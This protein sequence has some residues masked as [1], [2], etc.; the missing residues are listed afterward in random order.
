[1]PGKTSNEQIIGLLKEKPGFVSGETMAAVLGISRAA[2]WKRISLLRKSG[3]NIEASYAR[4]Y[5][6]LT[7]PDLSV[8]EIRSAFPVRQAGLGRE[9]ILLDR[10][11]STNTYAMELAARGA[12]EGTVILANEQ[13][14]GRGRRGRIWISPRGKSLYMSVVLRPGISPRDATILTFLSAVAV[15][16]AVSTLTSLPVTIKWPN[17]LM[18]SGRKLGGILTEMKADMDRIFHAVVGIGVNI[19]LEREALPEEIRSIATSVLAETG[20]SFRRAPFAVGILREMEKQYRTL[21]EK[22]RHPLLQE[23]LSLN[24]T[25]G[26][27]VEVTAGEG[28]IAGFAEGIDDEGMLL[29]RLP[30]GALRR[31]GSGDVTYGS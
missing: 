26:R 27:H 21:Q 6:L 17:D 16:T 7:S 20:K 23:W 31:I 28:K 9:V 5:R 18:V 13:T 15:A 29:L 1:M 10:I 24:S 30:D 12:P 11:D 22:G 19:N 3:Y 2:L 8:E 4:G 25:I 14:G